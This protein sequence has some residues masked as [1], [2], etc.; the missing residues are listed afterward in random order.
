MLAGKHVIA[1]I[2]VRNIDAARQFYEGKLGL[3]PDSEEM[4]GVVNYD[5]G[6]SR[7]LVYESEFAG[8]NQA[9]AATWMVGDDV[10]GVAES[11]K[12]KGVGFERYDVP[13]TSRDG[14]V[15]IFG[16]IKVAW[17]KDPDGNIHSIVNG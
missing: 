11:L 9:T 17:F 8:T 7:L 4:Q 6:G 14:D 10:K 2:P 3:R 5:T 15:H 13:V 12:A 1:T 16:E